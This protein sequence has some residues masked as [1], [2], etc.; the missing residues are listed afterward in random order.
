M[1]ILVTGGAGFIG[2]SISGNPSDLLGFVMGQGQA[3]SLLVPTRPWVWQKTL[4]KSV[5]VYEAHIRLVKKL[6]K[7]G[8][9]M[10]RSVDS[11]LLDKAQNSLMIT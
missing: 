10:H 7:Q 5:K 11:L 4:E 8:V 9:K 2:T 6:E 1:R 3:T